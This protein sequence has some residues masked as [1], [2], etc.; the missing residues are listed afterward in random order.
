MLHPAGQAQLLEQR[1]RGRSE[2]QTVDFGPEAEQPFSQPRPLETRVTG[3]ED[4]FA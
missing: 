1:A 4:A 2:A 3:K